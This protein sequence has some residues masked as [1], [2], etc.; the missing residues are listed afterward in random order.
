MAIPSE[1]E[2]NKRCVAAAVALSMAHILTG[3]DYQVYPLDGLRID[4]F[5]LVNHAV[6]LLPVVVLLLM[7]K[8]CLFVR[9]YG[10]PVLIIF[11]LRMHH[12]WQFYWF[13]RKRQGMPLAHELVGCAP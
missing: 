8:A 11:V 5:F 2:P 1:D 12:V 13:G 10:V 6:F 9:I 3:A 4:H 7:R